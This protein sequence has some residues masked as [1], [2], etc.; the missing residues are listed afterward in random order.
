MTIIARKVLLNFKTIS[1]EVLEPW[2]APTLKSWDLEKIQESFEHLFKNNLQ[3]MNKK[4]CDWL[5]V[6]TLH[7]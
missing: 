4:P 7:S 1:K 3:N 6:F 5:S 2:W